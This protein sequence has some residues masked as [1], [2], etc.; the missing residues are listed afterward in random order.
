V[1]LWTGG[2][3]DI[4]LQLLVNLVLILLGGSLLMIRLYRLD[5]REAFALRA[6]HPASWLA[7]VVGSPSA[8]VLGIGLAE[9]V[10]R[11]VFPVPRRMIESFGE[12]FFGPDLPVWQI[13]FF[14]GVLPGVLEELT[15]RGVLLHGLSKRLRPWAV[16][17]VV[18]G[19]FGFFHVSL[20]RIVPTAWLG[21]VMAA[22][23][24]LTGSVFPAMLWHFL[25]NTVAL[26]SIEMGWLPEDFRVE[27]WLTAVAAVGLALS[28]WIFWRTRRPYPGLRPWRARRER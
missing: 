7:V 21:V 26:V 19:V 4:R 10:N 23:T 6:P 2:G 28:F 16:A 17:L 27:P 8:M 18:G 13:V 15:F 25:N 20:F 1:S 11:W 24:L 14:F 22:A 9:M 3:L 5:W 12:A